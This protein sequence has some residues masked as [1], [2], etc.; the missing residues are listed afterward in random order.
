MRRQVTGRSCN[1]MIISPRAAHQSLISEDRDQAVDHLSV[2]CTRD[3]TTVPDTERCQSDY[4]GPRLPELARSSEQRARQ[5]SGP[6][7]PGD[8]PSHRGGQGFKS[9]QLHEEAAGKGQ[10]PAIRD[11]AL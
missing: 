10:D 6:L 9:P 1:T 11:L 2:I 5:A 3:E 7:N 8:S 4:E